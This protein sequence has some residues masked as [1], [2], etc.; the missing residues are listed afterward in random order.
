MALLHHDDRWEPDFLAATAPVLDTDPEVGMVVVGAEDIDSQGGSLGVRPSRMTPGKQSDALELLLARDFM[1]ML[2]SVILFRG[3]ALE[4]NRRP[5][6]DNNIADVT[7]YL[8][9]AARGWKLFHVAEVLAQYRNHPEQASVQT[10]RHRRDAAAL[11]DSY[12][13][14]DPLHERLRR[15]RVSE[16]LMSEAG[17]EIREGTPAAARRALRRGARLSLR[18]LGARWA[19]IWFLSF[20]PGLVPRV[21]AHWARVRDPVATRHKG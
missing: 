7:M 10:V 6:P 15:R 4:A 8:D 13:F 5:W 17:I 12:H 3:R 9:V 18:A 21:H 11:W 19:A 2:P 20:V 1:L 14:E 16:A